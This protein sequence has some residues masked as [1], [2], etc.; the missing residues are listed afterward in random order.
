MFVTCSAELD[1]RRA[2]VLRRLSRTFGS[3][4]HVSSSGLG[5]RGPHPQQS[6]QQRGH[7]KID[8]Q[9]LELLH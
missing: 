3:G 7:N 8:D 6:L 2:T 4:E 9:L 5:F 1:P